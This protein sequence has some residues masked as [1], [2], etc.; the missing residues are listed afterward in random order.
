MIHMTGRFGSPRSTRGRL[1]DRM[2]WEVLGDRGDRAVPGTP[3]LGI[4]KI[5][6]KPS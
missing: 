5:S 1:G 4:L 2:G 6:T 3:V